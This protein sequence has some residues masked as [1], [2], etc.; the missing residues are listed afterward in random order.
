MVLAKMR[1]RRNPLPFIEDTAKFRREIAKREN[2]YR[3]NPT[4]LAEGKETAKTELLDRIRKAG[5]I[6]KANDRITFVLAES[7]GFCWGVERSI[8]IAELARRKFPKKQIFLT[9]ELIHNP[10]VNAKLRAQGVVFIKRRAD[11]SRD[12]SPIRGGDVVILP[13]FGAPISEVAFL[14]QAGAIIVDSTCPW[15]TKVWNVVEKQKKAGVTTII[16]GNSDHEETEATKSIAGKYI[17]VKNETE[18]GLIARFISLG[19]DP[20]ALLSAFKPSAYSA[21]F[22][23]STDLKQIGIANQTTMLKSETESI[24]R[25]LKSV[26]ET[27]YGKGSFMAFNTICDATQERQDAMNKLINDRSL[28]FDVMLIVGG[29][30]S[31]NTT[32]LLEIAETAQ[33]IKRAFHI[34]SSKRINP[35]VNAIEHKR[36][37]GP[38]ITDELLPVTSNLVIGITSGASTPDEV[39]EDCL[40]RILGIK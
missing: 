37:H 34:D 4:E 15:V 30:N 19:G 16:H 1:R 26:V 32:H 20:V 33:N 39:V 14:D 6:F 5:N 17:C 12:L 10:D 13:A 7:F 24:S 36:L 11:G 21:N 31:S 23:P 3:P 35:E 38:V 25:L 22:D 2:F 28:Q 18:A 29:F 27:K 8:A 9:N 40:N